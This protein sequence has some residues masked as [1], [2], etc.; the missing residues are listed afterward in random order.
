MAA[1]GIE[2]V[3]TAYLVCAVP[4]T[5]SWLLCHALEQSG[6]AGAPAEY[7]WRGDMNVWA[8]RWGTAN[9]AEYVEAFRRTATPNG[10]VGAKMMWGYFDDFF[11]NARAVDAWSELEDDA[12]LRAVFGDLRFL[13]IRRRDKVRQGVSWWRAEVTGEW[14][15]TSDVAGSRPPLELNLAAVKNL[16]QV[17]EAHELAWQRYFERR[18][19]APWTVDYED[20]VTDVTG[21]VL[22]A[23][24]H[25]G[26]EAP[27]GFAAAPRLRQQADGQTEQW[28]NDYQSAAA[29]GLLDRITAVA[30]TPVAG[31][32][33]SAADTE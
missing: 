25:L 28:V 29:S 3:D 18:G 27:S 4:R 30:Q 9:F 1:G 26:L 6:V 10:V 13:W 14:A 31:H 5:G 22:Q 19:I 7:F 11:T 24:D 15:R 17:A 8:E 23:L 20:L 2:R 16:V 33:P 12:I 21:A 32:V